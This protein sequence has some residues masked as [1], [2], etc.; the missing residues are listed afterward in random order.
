VAVKDGLYVVNSAAAAVHQQ[1]QAVG[2]VN[3][4]V[5]AE[6]VKSAL[7]PSQQQQQQGPFYLHNPNGLID[8]PVKDIFAAAADKP[9]SKTDTYV[10]AAAPPP[11]PPPPAIGL[12][13]MTGKTLRLHY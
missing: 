9:A 11:P 12:N 5:I 2:K 3:V 1:Q 10:V 13:T 6:P 4:A 8:D 7:P